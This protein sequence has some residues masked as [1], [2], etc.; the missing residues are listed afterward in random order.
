MNKLAGVGSTRDWQFI[1]KAAA[2]LESL[3]PV[4][5]IPT[6]IRAGSCTKIGVNTL[7]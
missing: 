1:N 7:A 4:D 2:K 3:E 5:S 6:I